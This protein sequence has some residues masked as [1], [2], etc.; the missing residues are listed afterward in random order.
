MFSIHPAKLIQ[1]S[2]EV[3]LN[4]KAYNNRVLTLWLSAELGSAVS[5]GFGGGDELLTLACI[6]VN[7]VCNNWGYVFFLK[8]LALIL[9]NPGSSNCPGPIWPV[10]SHFWKG[11]TDTCNLTSKLLVVIHFCTFSR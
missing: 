9:N 3:L 10:S 7:Q 8:S 1:K 6:C 11:P 4:G 5:Q 2:G